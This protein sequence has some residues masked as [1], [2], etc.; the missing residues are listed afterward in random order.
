[1]AHNVSHNTLA[2][3]TLLGFLT[4]A[5]RPPAVDA[6]QPDQDKPAAGDP[7]VARIYEHLNGGAR[8]IV[9]VVEAGRFPDPVWRRVKNLVAFRIHRPSGNGT[10][11]ADAATYL[12]RDSSIYTTA[13][14]ALRN[15]STQ[16]EYTCGACSPRLLRTKLRTTSRAPSAKRSEPKPSS[17]AAACLPATCILRMAGVR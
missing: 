13:A 12:V 1:M 6:N 15:N 17:Y 16:K 5:V 11:V 10:T 7:V 9:L 8:P 3:V 2:I 14:A 4:T